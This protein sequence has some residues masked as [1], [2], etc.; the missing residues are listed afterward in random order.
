MNDRWLKNLGGSAVAAMALLVGVTLIGN[1]LMPYPEAPRADAGSA[2]TPTAKPD[3]KADSTANSAAPAVGA[4]NASLPVRLALA[5]ARRGATVAKK[6]VAC[7]PL[8]KD[9]KAKVGPGL[10]GIVGKSVASGDFKFSDAMTRLGGVWSFERLDA[11]IENPKTFAP[12]NKM[13]FAG[14]ANGAERADLLL[15]MRSLSDAPVALPQASAAELAAARNAPAAAAPVEAAIPQ[16]RD[17]AFRGVAGVRPYERPA[18]APVIARAVKAP[19]WFK[20]ALTG[21][22]EPT[23]ASLGFLKDQEFWFNPFSRPGMPAPYDLRGW[24]GTAK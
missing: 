18:D 10:W 12:G 22:S 19:E 24:H 8:E 17:P 21:V 16:D 15:H 3:K 2:T 23:P 20:L 9:A 6:C 11:Y 1:V 4:A 13:A 7:H 5:D 14:I